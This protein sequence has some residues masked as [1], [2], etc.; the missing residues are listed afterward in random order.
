M[1]IPPI[2]AVDFSRWGEVEA[3]ELSRIK[4]ISG[5]H[6]HRCWLNIPM[7]THH[8]EADIT[9]LEEFRKSLKSQ[10][11][12]EHLDMPVSAQEREAYADPRYV[13]HLDAMKEAV[14]IDEHNRFMRASAEAK[15]EAW[16]TQSS[17]QRSMKI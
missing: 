12:R 13:S 2:P 1:A 5:A 6:L 17:N 7:V 8:D 15:I 3:R 14:R 9:D 10:I 16:R 4:K 11:M